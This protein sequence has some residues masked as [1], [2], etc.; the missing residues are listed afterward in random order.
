MHDP[1]NQSPFNAP[2][3]VVVALAA[4]IIGLEV[5]FQAA[6]AG[7]VGGRQAVGWRLN[8][9]RDWAVD[10]SVVAWMIETGQAPLRQ[11]A[12]FV[13]YPLIHGSFVHAAFVVVFV[14]ALGNVCAPVFPSWRLPILFWAS[15]V[16]G[17]LV[18]VMLFPSSGPLFGGYPGAYGLI[19]VFTLLTR[20][21]LTRVDP[22]RAFLLIGFLL[23]IQPIFGLAGGLGFAW[24][25]DW[26]ADIAGFAAGYGLAQLM[27][28]GG[29]QGLIGRMRQR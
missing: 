5:M 14:L 2:P 12:R 8:A 29:L 23:A 18:Y 3:P 27:F 17:A 19:G 26:I 24:F 4:L 22:D 21:G 10:G 1:R 28:P 20:K 13:T 16:A 7:F 25:P 11:L 15:A 9:I 6:E